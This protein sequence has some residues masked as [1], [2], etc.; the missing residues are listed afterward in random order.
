MQML[1]SM[2]DKKQTKVLI[3]DDEVFICQQLN[4]MLQALDYEVT[5]MAFNTESAINSLIE[6]PPDI[7]HIGY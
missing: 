6:N 4:S 1:N 2:P 3:V 7:S 5:M